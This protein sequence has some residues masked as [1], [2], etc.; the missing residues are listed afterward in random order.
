MSRKI[1]DITGQRFGKLVAIKPSEK[2][3]R[4]GN[5]FWLCECDCG[6]QHICRANSLKSG[7]TKSCGC[8]KFE[9]CGQLDLLGQKF[10][11]LTPIE[12]CSSRKYGGYIVWKCLCECGNTCLKASNQL[13]RSTGLSC[14]CDTHEKLRINGF[15]SQQYLLEDC[16]EGTNAKIIA[17]DTKM[18]SNNTSGTTGVS[19]SKTSNK[20]KATISFKQK[21]YFLGSFIEKEDAIK[22]R[23][24]AEERLVEPF[25]EW[26]A[27]QKAKSGTDECVPL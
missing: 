1:I 27:A 19:W 15:N 9:C 26:Y 21:I 8:L 3:E 24:R 12:K 14:G 17:P 18:Y 2:K 22:A 7:N 5:D 6:R 13:K 4:C 11:K 23:R 16:V 25:L 20:W 10:G